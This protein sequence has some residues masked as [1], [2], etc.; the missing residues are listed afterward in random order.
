MSSDAAMVLIRNYFIGRTYS[1]RC[2]TNTIALHIA[3]LLCYCEKDNLC[4]L[5]DSRRKIFYR[6]KL[7]MPSSR[8][9]P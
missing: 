5:L 7:T 9:E 2:P 3:Q 8:V 6:S 1:V 4:N